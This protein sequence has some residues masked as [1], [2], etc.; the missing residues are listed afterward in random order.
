MNLLL[1]TH[2]FLWWLSGSPRLSKSAS[3]RISD[4]GVVV[5]VSS[6][7]IW[8]AAIKVQLGRLDVAGADL[9]EEISINGF[10]E[11]AISARH[12]QRAGELVQHHSDPFDRML[13]AQAELERLTVVSRD[14]AFRAYEIPLLW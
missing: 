3:E 9:V 4:S 6:V 1:D 7:S 8:E 12:A 14:Q 2:A 13:I 10:S 11:L 5:F